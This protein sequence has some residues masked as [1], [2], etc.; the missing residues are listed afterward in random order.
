MKLT[1][2]HFCDSIFVS[3]KNKHVQSVIDTMHADDTLLVEGVGFDSEHDVRQNHF[4]QDMIGVLDRVYKTKTAEARLKSDR[5]GYE[6]DTLDYA[7]RYALLRGISVVYADMDSFE[8]SRLNNMMGEEGRDAVG[9]P[10]DSRHL[11]VAN[12]M[13]EKRAANTVK[14]IALERLKHSQTQGVDDGGKSRLILLYGADHVGELKDQLTT[15]VLMSMCS[16]KPSTIQ[17]TVKGNM[18]N[19]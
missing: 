3:R 19:V 17:S 14:D 8:S 5:D 10:S 4:G 16:Q 6:L 9:M 11:E 2:Y 13:R 1:C 15:L 7:M 12:S 18:G